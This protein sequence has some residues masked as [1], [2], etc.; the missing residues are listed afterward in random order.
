M[1]TELKDVAAEVRGSPPDDEL[2][3]AAREAAAVFN[4][5]PAA[6]AVPQTQLF[7]TQEQLEE[8]DRHI[9]AALDEMLE[10]RAPQPQRRQPAQSEES[11]IERFVIGMVRKGAGLTSLSLVLVFMGIVVLYCFFSE[12]ADL[13]LPLKLSPVAAIL[14]GLELLVYHLAS[15]KKFRVHIPAIVLT[16]LIIAGCC[17][18]AV[19][20]NDS[21]AESKEEFNNRTIAAQVYESGYHELRLVADIKHIEVEVDLN[22][23]GSA[24]TEGI[25]SLSAD[26]TVILT[27]TFSG[28]YADAEDFASECRKVIDAYRF[29][30]IP[31]TEF[32]FL[33]DSMFNSYRLDVK[34]LFMQEMSESELAGEVFCLYV[35][36]YDYLEDLEDF[37]AET[38]ENGIDE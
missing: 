29:L 26:D 24:R 33:S 4:E 6:E 5:P 31:V 25:D 1:P 14:L 17:T 16:A 10:R 23:D 18:M 36:D 38:S 11:G 34:G 15:G 20:M 19:V 12:N 27:V 37:V 2:S 30:D 35:E 9:L 22:P 8:H 7:H 28:V 32:H 21:Y 3:A 13:L